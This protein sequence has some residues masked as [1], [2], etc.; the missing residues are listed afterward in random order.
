MT[1]EDAKTHI[2]YVKTMK[3]EIFKEMGIDESVT[4]DMIEAAATIATQTHWGTPDISV[5]NLFNSTLKK[6]IE[7]K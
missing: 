7:D 2:Q 3:P 6:L 5:E 4:D 1:L